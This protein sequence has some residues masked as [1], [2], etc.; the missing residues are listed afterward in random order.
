MITQSID[1]TCTLDPSIDQKAKGRLGSFLSNSE[2]VGSHDARI[3]R[4]SDGGDTRR[5]RVACVDI[6]SVK[7][8][9]STSIA[10]VSRCVVY[11]RSVL[12]LNCPV[13]MITQSHH[14]LILTLQQSLW[15]TSNS[16][17]SKHL[18]NYRQ[19]QQHN[20]HSWVGRRLEKDRGFSW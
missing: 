17:T 20:A 19:P 1:R 12:E 11:K 15:S 16:S 8:S 7:R 13:C 6:V 9:T 18:T 14:S 10:S 4:P 5:R 3:A 2:D